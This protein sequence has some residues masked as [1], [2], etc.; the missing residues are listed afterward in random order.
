MVS[1]VTGLFRK[2][3]ASFLI[4]GKE[5]SLQSNRESNGSDIEAHSPKEKDKPIAADMMRGPNFGRIGSER[6]HYRESE[7]ESERRGVDVNVKFTF[8]K[9]FLEE[10]PHNVAANTKLA[11]EESATTLSEILNNGEG[12]LLPRVLGQN[13][14][15]RA[16]V[17]IPSP[18]GNKELVYF[19]PHQVLKCNKYICY[20]QRFPFSL[21]WRIQK[22]TRLESRKSLK[23]KNQREEEIRKRPNCSGC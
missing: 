18:R 21:F 5:A 8:D 16:T 6:R 14:R 12:R 22:R 7:E 13:H 9:S 23:E 10:D 4:E 20:M 11:P 19:D 2:S 17:S 1:A 15:Q 3:L